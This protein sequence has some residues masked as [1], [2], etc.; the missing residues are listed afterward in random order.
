MGPEDREQFTI[1]ITSLAAAFGREPTEPLLMGYWL[2]LENMT[3]AD[4]KRAACLAMKESKFMPV[5]AELRELA[6][7]GGVKPEDRAVLA[8]QTVQCAMRR[9]GYYDS[10]DFADKTINAAI[11][12]LGGWE[13]ICI[14]DEEQDPKWLRQEF[15]RTYAALCRTG[16]AADLTPP[17]VG[18]HDRENAFLGYHDAVKVPQLVAVNHNGRK[19]PMPLVKGP[20]A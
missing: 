1:V 10:V 12:T 7:I 13:G 19:I 9:F 17:L 11:R 2:G 15:E 20:D 5:P 16:V 3:L 6:G 4:V 18:F 14:R 8:W